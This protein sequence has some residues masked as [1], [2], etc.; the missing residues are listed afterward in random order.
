[1]IS[2]KDLRGR[3]ALFEETN[4]IIILR[5]VAKLWYA[6][7]LTT[8]WPHLQI[9]AHDEPLWRET[10]FYMRQLLWETP[11]LHKPSRGYRPQ[12]HK[13]FFYRKRKE[14]NH[15]KLGWYTKNHMFGKPWAWKKTSNPFPPVLLWKN[16]QTADAC[17]WQG[18]TSKTPRRP[19]QQ[20]QPPMKD[21][22]RSVVCIMQMGSYTPSI[23]T[24]F[25]KHKNDE[26]TFTASI[27][28]FSPSWTMSS[29]RLFSYMI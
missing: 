23:D 17:V 11:V 18:L 14:L 10:K 27:F 19:C 24:S 26:H 5:F 8:L 3:S 20:Q 2:L 25:Q 1:M 12:S 4:S 21:K 13:N 7:T 28:L 22:T 9:H 29:F 16:K 6:Y 15:N